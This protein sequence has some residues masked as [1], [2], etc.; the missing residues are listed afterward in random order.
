LRLDCCATASADWRRPAS[1]ARRGNGRR[2]FRVH[3]AESAPVDLTSRQCPG[4]G[5]CESQQEGGSPCDGILHVLA[6]SANGCVAAGG[7]YRQLTS[8]FAGAT[9]RTE[10]PTFLFTFT[11][12]SHSTRCVPRGPCG[13]P[14]NLSGLLDG[15]GAA[16]TVRLAAIPDLYRPGGRTVAWW[17]ISA[18]IR[19]GISRKSSCLCCRSCPRS[20]GAVRERSAP[21]CVILLNCLRII[22]RRTPIATAIP[23]CRSDSPPWDTSSDLSRE[24]GTITIEGLPAIFELSAATS[25]RHDRDVHAGRHPGR[26]AVRRAAA[27]GSRSTRCCSPVACAESTP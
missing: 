8:R 11:Q 7:P 26:V 21:G 16:E 3:A 6:V 10:N 20:T 22:R 2:S 13:W 25:R 5:R 12:F 14:T 18:D 15:C 1:A 4:L 23:P 19:R 24:W 17:S 27:M 9:R